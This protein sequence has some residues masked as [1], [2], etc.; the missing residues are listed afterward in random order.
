[1]DNDKRPKRIDGDGGQAEH[2]RDAAVGAARDFAKALQE[3]TEPDADV[4]RIA[5]EALARHPE[6]DTP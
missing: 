3:V 6:Y 2:E 1:V 4:W 5:T